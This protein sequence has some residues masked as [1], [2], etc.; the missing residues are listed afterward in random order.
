MSGRACNSELHAFASMSAQKFSAAFVNE[1][2][3]N[4]VKD[5]KIYMYTTMLKCIINMYMYIVL[6]QQTN[7]T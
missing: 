7:V 1:K 3:T 4:T 5:E 6:L 2:Q